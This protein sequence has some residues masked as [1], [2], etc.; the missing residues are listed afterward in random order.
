MQFYIQDNNI[1]LYFEKKTIV[2][3]MLSYRKFYIFLHSLTE[4]WLLLQLYDRKF[5]A[6]L[7]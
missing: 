6:V 2:S 5:E 3:E 4:A 7:I 1:S